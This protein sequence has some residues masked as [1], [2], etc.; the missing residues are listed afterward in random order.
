M[1]CKVQLYVS[2]TVFDEIVIARNYE[3]AR[4]IRTKEELN[5]PQKSE[6]SKANDGEREE[7]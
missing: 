5:T 6:E 3:E 2:G 4:K 1:K 7:S